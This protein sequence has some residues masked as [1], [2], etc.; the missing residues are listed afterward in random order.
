MLVRFQHPVP[1]IRGLRGKPLCPRQLFALIGAHIGSPVFCIRALHS[2]GPGQSLL[3]SECRFESGSAFQMNGDVVQRIEGARL[4]TLRS[5]FNSLHPFHLYEGSATPSAS[6]RVLRPRQLLAL[7][8]RAHWLTQ[9]PCL[10][11]LTLDDASVLTKRSGL[12]S[13][14]EFHGRVV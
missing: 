6:L 2:T 1:F 5:G 4:R 7:L 13:R 14:R 8:R 12:D 10:R 9:F 3:S 11:G